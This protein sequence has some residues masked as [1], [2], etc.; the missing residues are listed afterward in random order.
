MWFPVVCSVVVNV[1]CA[2]MSQGNARNIM[3]AVIAIGH[4]STLYCIVYIRNSYNNNNNNNNGG[5]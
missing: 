5:V 1:L 3:A 4:V 2:Y